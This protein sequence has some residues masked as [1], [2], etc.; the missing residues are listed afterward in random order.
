V[1]QNLPSIVDLGGFKSVIPVVLQALES[2]T[3]GTE[4]TSGLLTATLKGGSNLLC[5]VSSPNLKINFAKN[6]GLESLRQV[7]DSALE[8]KLFGIKASGLF[9]SL[10]IEVKRIEITPEKIILKDLPVIGKFEV[11]IKDIK[12]KTPELTCKN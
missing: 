6:F 9:G 12:G 7:N 1:A 5:S 8:L 4:L 3:S 10:A 11:K 2:A